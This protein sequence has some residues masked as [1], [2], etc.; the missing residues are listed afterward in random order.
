MEQA[1]QFG[2]V[3]GRGRGRAVV[4]DPLGEFAGPLVDD[5]APGALQEA[6]NAVD[7]LGLPWLLLVERPHEQ[8]VQPERV[9]A[10]AFDHVVRIG[11]V[12]LRLGHLLDP[13]FER[14]VRAGEEHPVVPPVDG[15]GVVVLAALVAVAVGQDHPL[16]EE[17]GERLGGRDQAGVVEHLLPEAG[18]EQ[19]QHRVLDAADIQVDRHPVALQLA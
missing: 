7:V 13:G 5:Q 16:V 9:R 15:V 11:D 19:M 1:V 2:C 8:F 12:E 18:V 6:V 4:S 17:P 10:P 14:L 3:F